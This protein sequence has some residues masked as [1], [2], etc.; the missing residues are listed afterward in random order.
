MVKKLLQSISSWQ[1]Q[2]PPKLIIINDRM[3]YLIGS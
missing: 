1:L 2:K 3:S